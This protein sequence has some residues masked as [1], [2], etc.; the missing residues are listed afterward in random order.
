VVV[1]KNLCYETRL[2]RAGKRQTVYEIIHHLHELNTAKLQSEAER[3]K[4]D[5][6]E[7]REIIVELRQKGLIYSPKPGT[8]TCVD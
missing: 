3:K 2:A 4:I 8:F 7:L 1:R 6:G 5:S